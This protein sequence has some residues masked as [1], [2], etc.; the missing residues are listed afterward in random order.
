M[1][2]RQISLL[3]FLLLLLLGLSA[4]GP[5]E[6]SDGANS[7]E[8]YFSGTLLSVDEEQAVVRL[9][10]EDPTELLERCTEVQ[11]PSI[12]YERENAPH[13]TP[14]VG[15]RVDGIYSTSRF[16]VEQVTDTR[17]EIFVYG[18]GLPQY[19][20]KGTV[21]AVEDGWVILTVTDPCGE[22][23]LEQMEEL[24]LSE[25]ELRTAGGGDHTEESFAP[26]DALLVTC[27]RHAAPAVPQ[28]VSPTY[29]NRLP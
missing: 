13:L 27:V 18:W 12:D 29:W 17:A 4:C 28:Q 16:P 5:G 24:W 20:C 23:L 10:P 21:R 2:F 1:M 11:F 8:G 9:D 26:G 14:Q 6:G 25:A 7:D 22:P 15:D 3:S 19:Q